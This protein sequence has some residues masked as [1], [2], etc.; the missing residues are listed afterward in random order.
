MLFIL[1]QLSIV[2]SQTEIEIKD[3]ETVSGSYNQAHFR[4]H[5]GD[6][7]PDADLTISLTKRRGQYNPNIYVKLNAIPTEDDYGWKGDSSGPDFLVIAYS[8][9]VSDSD[10]HI[11]VT[12]D[13]NNDYDITVSH[14]S[15]IVLTEGLGLD[16][17]L[18]KG[19]D[20]IFTFTPPED[21]LSASIILYTH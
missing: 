20:A 4:F 9:L 15:E 8:E 17:T 2:F 13:R 16:I 6:I 1:L 12:T 19:Y 11:L 7:T 5:L 3:G 21:I 10:Y 18:A 14:S